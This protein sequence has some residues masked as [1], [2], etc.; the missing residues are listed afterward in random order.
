MATKIDKATLMDLAEKG[1]AISGGDADQN[2][3]P[4]AEMRKA[5]RSAKLDDG[6]KLGARGEYLSASY[7]SQ[8]GNIRTDR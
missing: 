4:P 6:P 2:G 3:A 8:R 7:K 1:E 5:D